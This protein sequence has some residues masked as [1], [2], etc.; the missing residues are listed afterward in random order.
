MARYLLFV[1]SDCKD[2]AREDEFNDW[3]DNT[4]LPDML[5]VPGTIRASRWASAEPRENQRRKYLALY[6]METDDL[7]AFGEKVRERGLRTMEEG[8]FSDLP[9]FDH[10]DIP[11]TYRQITPERQAANPGQP[12]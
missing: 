12:D 10:P 4:H 7:K 5:E 6:E 3:Y 8:R 11:R 9:V 1:F 2:P